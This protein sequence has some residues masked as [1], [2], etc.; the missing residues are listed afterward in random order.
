MLGSQR[1]FQKTSLPLKNARLTPGVARRLDVRALVAGPVLVVADRQ[2]DVVLEQLGAA[3]IGVDARRVADVVAV[4][5]EPAHHR[6]LG[7]EQAVLV[8][9]SGRCSSGS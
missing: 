2:E 5:L 9:P 6:I 7:V 4:A 1:V 3:P 8:A